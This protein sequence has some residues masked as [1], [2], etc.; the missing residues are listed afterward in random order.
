M[1]G[2]WDNDND[3]DG[4][5]DDGESIFGDQGNVDQNNPLVS[6]EYDMQSSSPIANVSG[7]VDQPVALVAVFDDQGLPMVARHVMQNDR[8]V[9]LEEFRRPSPDEYNSI[10]FGGKIVKGGVVGQEALTRTGRGLQ[11][12]PLGI[13]GQVAEEPKWKK[14]A[15]WGAGIGVTSGVG[16]LGYR[17]WKNRK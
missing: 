5:F 4:L 16:Y 2:T 7:S 1:S 6:K 11:K 8:P 10:M 12:T 14:V 13:F 17:W 3:D 15:K 9:Q